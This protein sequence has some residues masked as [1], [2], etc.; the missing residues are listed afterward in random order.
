[1]F[2]KRAQFFYQVNV[3]KFSF[4]AVFN[5]SLGSCGHT[6]V[7]NIM[8]HREK[9][10]QNSI[11]ATFKGVCADINPD[12]RYRKI[13]RISFGIRMRTIDVALLDVGSERLCIMQDV[14]DVL[15]G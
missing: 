5:S 8:L 12:N 13:P 4:R 15:K 14:S 3:V 9:A 1:M 7:R 11:L 6:Y 2:L 10:Y